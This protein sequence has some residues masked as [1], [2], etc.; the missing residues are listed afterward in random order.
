MR[1]GLSE[2]I[3]E[4]KNVTYRKD[5]ITLLNNV[6]F[7]L[8]KGD[9][10]TIFGPEGSGISSLFDIIIRANADFEGDVFYKGVA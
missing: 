6:S 4:L 10:V 8:A 2:A 9:N 7:S 3:L 5:T 1:P